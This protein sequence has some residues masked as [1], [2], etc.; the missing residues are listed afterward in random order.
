MD[1]PQL[2]YS[3]LLNGV[4]QLVITKADVL[5]TFPEIKIATSYRYDGMEQSQLPY[6]LE[7]I[8]VTPIY[9]SFEGWQEDLDSIKEFDRL[10]EKLCTYLKFIESMVK[11][12]IRMI[13]TGPERKKLIVNESFQSV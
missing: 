13:S 12:P 1:L 11:V 2:K 3:I 4:T 5:N 10:P 6:D 9:T 8:R 7:T